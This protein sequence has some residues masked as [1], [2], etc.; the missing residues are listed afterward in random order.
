[1]VIALAVLQ[2]LKVI[3]NAGANGCRSAEIHIRTFYGSYLT[4]SHEGTVHGSI[5][6][7]IDGKQII[8]IGLGGIAIQIE[9]RMV[10]HIDNSG[11]V[12]FGTVTNVDGIVICQRESDLAG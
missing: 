5:G 7:C 10:R 4:G 2:L 6:I 8:R 12:C 11:T 3:V 1:M 9:V